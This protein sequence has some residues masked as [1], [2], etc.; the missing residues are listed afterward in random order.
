MPTLTPIERLPSYLTGV[1]SHEIAHIIALEGKVSISKSDLYLVLRNREENVELKEKKAEMIYEY[2]SKPI[3]FEIN[4]WD[5][6][7]M[8]KTIENIVSK[9]V[10]LVSQLNFDKIVFGENLKH[11]H[12]FI[13]SK[14]AESE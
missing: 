2:L 1:L 10:Q 11:F 6:T 8:R 3:R 5:R 9:D 4:R 7:R 14:L 13:K 12:D